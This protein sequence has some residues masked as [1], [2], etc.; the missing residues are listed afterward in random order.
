MSKSLARV[1]AALQASGLAAEPLE[2]PAETRTAVQAAAAAGCALDQIVKSILFQGLRSG[3]LYLFL[4]AGGNRVDEAR[5]AALTGEP[6]GRADGQT[7]RD[8][9][10]FAIGGVAPLGHLS[11]LPAWIDPRLLDFPQVW[12]AAGTP[13]HIFP[14]APGEL[15]RAA[16]AIR[17][18]FCRAM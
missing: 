4:T 7:V 18:D 15:A 13:R 12:A 16:G 8:V 9:T 2:M 5:A 1:R 6:L 3:R 17:A 11:P 14:A 10:G